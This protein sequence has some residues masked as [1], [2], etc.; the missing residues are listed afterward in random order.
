[1]TG[2]LAAVM[3]V[4]SLPFYSYAEGLPASQT[5]DVTAVSE[6]SVYTEESSDVLTEDESVTE[7][8]EEVSETVTETEEEQ[9]ETVTGSDEEKQ[10][11]VIDTEEETGSYP[12]EAE[13]PEEI[14]DQDE[15]LAGEPEGGEDPEESHTIRFEYNDEEVAGVETNFGAIESMTDNGDRSY[16]LEYDS[17][18]SW[19]FAFSVTPRPGYVVEAVKYTNEDHTDAEIAPAQ[20]GEKPYVMEDIWGYG[21]VTINI[22]M[23][24]KPAIAVKTLIDGYAPASVNEVSYEGTNENNK[25]TKDAVTVAFKLTEGKVPSATVKGGTKVGTVEEGEDLTATA[26]D[27]DGYYKFTLSAAKVIE[28][29]DA[30][31]DLT[32]NISTTSGEGYAFFILDTEEAEFSVVEMSG[33]SVSSGREYV[34][35]KGTDEISF[36]VSVPVGLESVV[37]LYNGSVDEGEI[38][39]DSKEVDK[40]HTKRTFTYK[41]ATA[42]VKDKKIKITEKTASKAKITVK[43]DAGVSKPSAYINGGLL[44]EETSME[45]TS[46]FLVT[47]FETVTVKASAADKYKLKSVKYKDTEQTK[48]VSS[49]S[50]TFTADNE[51]VV[52]FASEGIPT[53]VYKGV[54]YADKAKVELR[55]DDTGSLSVMSGS[56][57][58]ALTSYTVK[59][60]KKDIKDTGFAAIDSA[61]KIISIDAS[62]AASLGKS[63]ITVTMEGDFGKK[64]I[65]FVVAQEINPDAITIKGFTDG[66]ATQES[67][68]V[69]TYQITLNK[70]ADINRIGIATDDPSYV[71]GYV[72]IYRDSKG[73]LQLV[74]RTYNR[75][76]EGNIFIPTED[77]P[78]TL[79]DGTDKSVTLKTLT[80]KV[81][82]AVLPAPSASVPVVSDVDMILSLSI[83][84]AAQ[85]YANLV[86]KVEAKAVGNVAEGMKESVVKYYMVDAL[87]QQE[88]ITL[89]DSNTMGKGK[90]QK[91]NIAVSLFQVKDPTLTE[92]TGTG[93]RYNESNIIQDTSKLKEKVLKNQATK[94]PYYETGLGLNKKRTSITVGEKNVLLATAKFSS[95]TSYTILSK[96]ELYDSGMAHIYS[97]G[98]ELS[99]TSPD[100]LGVVVNDSAD[101]EPGKYTL[102]VFPTAPDGSVSKP[103]TMTVNVK[104]PVTDITIDVPSNKMYKASNKAATMKLKAS[105]SSIY[106]YK[107]ASTKLEWSLTEVGST[108]LKNALKINKNNG[109]VTLAKGYVLSPDE[110][111]N[112]FKVTVKALDLGDA[113][114]TKTTD[115]ITV[116][117]MSVTPSIMKIGDTYG[118]VGKDKLVAVYSDALDGRKLVITDSCG[119]DIAL[120]QMTLSVS[121]KS[122]LYIA[123][124]GN[125]AV[126]KAGTYT[127]KAVAKDGSK[128]SIS[129]KF[130]VA[131]KSKDE[132][133]PYVN[134]LYEMKNDKAVSSMT[135]ESDNTV[136]GSNLEYLMLYVIP[137]TGTDR[138]I[139]DNKA[140]VTFKNAK[141][142]GV[143]KDIYNPIYG[144]V[145]C[146][147]YVLKPTNDKDMEV[148]ITDKTIK[149]GGKNYS[150]TYKIKHPKPEATIKAK[151]YYAYYEK[152]GISI[153]LPFDLTGIDYE[154]NKNDVKLSFSLT[155]KDMF[156]EPDMEG[157]HQLVNILDDRYDAGFE[158]K[159]IKAEG[160]EDAASR[161]E[162]TIPGGVFGVFPVRSGSY[163]F[164]VSLWKKDGSEALTAPVKTTIIFVKTPQIKASIDPKISF[165]SNNRF[166]EFKFK[167]VKNVRA[168]EPEEL[169]N[170]VT[171]ASANDITKYFGVT[172][173]KDS[174][175]GAYKPVIAPK[176]T[177][178][179]PVGTKLTG[180]VLYKAYGLDLGVSNNTDTCSFVEKYEKI[181]VTITK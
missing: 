135:I 33:A 130:K 143:T 30:G 142:V 14:T 123:S 133:K 39:A 174:T 111:E 43:Y 20:S 31:E 5:D 8:S 148:T 34:I 139:C 10:E 90:A 42:S 55:S 179:P 77:I 84:K 60:G 85:S 154:S 170:D 53:L 28:A 178:L 38:T 47:E 103:A 88:F 74:V 12:E 37:M 146:D 7:T 117:N 24:E 138:A 67:G 44:A 76:S 70:G 162:I 83:P 69:K 168:I 92:G 25:A 160:E 51:S 94:A 175:T 79:V 87:S 150:V 156:K 57:T 16:T 155:E 86:Y 166:V 78:I 113:G 145:V 124:N 161:A 40:D 56:E 121:P 1:M 64:E 21:D 126:Y 153:K 63:P 176:T 102:R 180:W 177:S 112:S 108:A 22:T 140:K 72:Y 3:V 109:T 173:V 118:A 149:S 82:P 165:A 66:K 114:I 50:L 97:T 136:T 49:G 128:K 158:T 159:L 9:T 45:G 73:N 48:A 127:I 151:N 132:S 157:I 101:M 105:C 26:K 15:E 27:A 147:R 58:A 29:W 65:N 169:Y 81:A 46:Y 89:C 54:A 98:S 141:K 6:D 80:V 68:T 13:T 100:S 144:V 19:T 129:A 71:N 122:G 91:Y 32:F 75:D 61:N 163:D 167:N 172:M 4:T 106:G 164:Y 120:S 137:N 107:P 115:T 52:E 125:V 99:I 152:P 110:S 11:T 41:I 93:E 17:E 171:G 62:K 95:R 131:A 2:I 96:A 18:N 116:T 181:T 23:A 59:M 36:T 35:P 134:L 104:A 119:T